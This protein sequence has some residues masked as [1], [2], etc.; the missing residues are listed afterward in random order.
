MRK[1]LLMVGLL[2]CGVAFAAVKPANSLE[3]PFRQGWNLVTLLRPV[4]TGA[5]GAGRLLHC[6]PLRLDSAN[7]CYV[8]CQTPADLKVGA[9]YWVFSEAAQTLVL[10]LDLTQ[11]NWET[12]GLTAQGW[13]LIGQADNSTWQSH[14][15]FP[16]FSNRYLLRPPFSLGVP[17]SSP[18]S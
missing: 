12:A 9:A 16:F 7:G 4:V 10:T 6:H 13:N 11:T 1:L 8:R 2:A 14:V 17:A 15:S 5:D 3:I 18:V